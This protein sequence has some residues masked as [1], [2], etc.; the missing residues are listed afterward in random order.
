M[1]GF[2]KSFAE[3]LPARRPRP[4]GMLSDSA[5]PPGVA[6]AHGVRQQ[7]ASIYLTAAVLATVGFLYG[8]V[9]PLIFAVPHYESRI[10]GAFAPSPWNLA[11]L[12]DVVA[13][14]SAFVPLGF[15]WGAACN[16]VVPKSRAKLDRFVTV[17]LACLGLALL[18]ETLQIWIPLRDPS[19]RD[20]LALEW[21]AVLGYGLWHAAGRGTTVVLARGIERF[22]PAG[23]SPVFRFRWLA[24]FVALFAACLAVNCYANPTQ[25]FLLYRFR[26]TSLE[27]VAFALANANVKQA[28]DP[29]SVWLPSLLTTILLLGLCFAAQRGVRFVFARRA[30][31]SAI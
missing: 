27:D 22:S 8:S 29:R 26:S 11:Q 7:V 21:G 10:R 5:H 1:N 15:L 30:V 12:F 6:L 25:L 19:I 17:A 24:L 3:I 18:A 13:N 2:G 28:H 20:V 23:A 4:T 31:R 9:I 16:T 14:V